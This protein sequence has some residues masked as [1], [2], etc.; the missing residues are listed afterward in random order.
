MEGSICLRPAVY[1]GKKQ[2]ET[3]SLNL[4]V[5]KAVK[6]PSGNTEVKVLSGMKTEI[7]HRKVAL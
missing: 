3:I 7:A 6:T 1:S 5:T 4:K 2:N